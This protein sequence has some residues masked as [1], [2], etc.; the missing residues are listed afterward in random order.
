MH[1][2][3]NAADTDAFAPAVDLGDTAVDTRGTRDLVHHA[4]VG[5]AYRDSDRA[6]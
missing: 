6:E 4:R 1:L 2:I 3:A 5:Y